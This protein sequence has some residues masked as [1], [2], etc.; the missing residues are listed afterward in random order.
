M[1]SFFGIESRV[2]TRLQRGVPGSGKMFEGEF[3]G[4]D[5]QALQATAKRLE[6]YLNEFEAK[7]KIRRK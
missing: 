7:R 5:K 6:D 1:C 2:G 4:Q 3:I